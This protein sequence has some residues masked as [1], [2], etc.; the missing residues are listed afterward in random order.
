MQTRKSLPAQ[1]FTVVVAYED[2]A[3]GLR[4]LELHQRILA[5]WAD[6]VDFRLIIWKFEPLGVP[7]LLTKAIQDALSADL[8]VISLGGNHPLPAEAT[9]WIS[10]LRQKTVKETA[11]ALLV[12]AEH[13]S[14]SHAA[15]AL[16]L[17]SEVASCSGMP[18]FSS[19][20]SPSQRP[21]LHPSFSGNE[22]L[23]TAL[24]C[25][26]YQDHWGLNE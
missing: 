23:H 25:D 26:E 22:L 17:L 4:G 15:Q 21:R 6:K 18:F 5:R 14:T 13:Q 12:D 20:Q 19:M 24:H 2:Y 1:P 3:C 8:I 7:S 9:R 10:G 16:A 11:L